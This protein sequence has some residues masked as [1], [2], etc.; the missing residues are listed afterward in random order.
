M[1]NLTVVGNGGIGTAVRVGI[2]E[3]TVVGVTVGDGM[4]VAVGGAVTVN[5]CVGLATTAIVGVGEDMGIVAGVE[6]GAVVV[7]KMLA[8]GDIQV[9]ANTQAALTSFL[10]Q[11]P[12]FGRRWPG[13]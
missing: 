13:Q 10:A 7:L 8:D 2:G 9:R 4:L 5:A 3:G 11:P 12:A 6:N 1:L